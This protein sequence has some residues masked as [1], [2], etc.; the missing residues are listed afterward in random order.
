MERSV[1]DLPLDIPIV[2][3]Y[4]RLKKRKNFSFFYEKK[5][6]SLFLACQT[7]SELKTEVLKKY[8]I[9]KK[10]LIEKNFS[11]ILKQACFHLNLKSSKAKSFQKDT[12]NA[13]LNEIIF[14]IAAIEPLGI[15]VYPSKKMEDNEDIRN[16]IKYLFYDLPVSKQLLNLH[17]IKAIF[18][19]K[20]P[21]F[22]SQVRSEFQNI[23]N[24]LYKEI[25]TK[26]HDELIIEMLIGNILSFYCYMQPKHHELIVIPQKIDGHFEEIPFRVEKIKLTPFIFGSPIYA[27]GLKPLTQKGHPIFLCKGTTYPQDTGFVAAIMTDFTPFFSVGGLIYLFYKKKI[28]KWIKETYDQYQ[29]ELTIYGQSLGGASAYH[30]ALDNPNMVKIYGY[31]PPGLLRSTV[32]K[33]KDVLINGKIFCHENDFVHLLGKHPYGVEFY[34]IITEAK[35]N[36]FTAHS[37]AFGSEEVLVLRVNE[38]KDNNRAVRTVFE[39][40]HQLASVLIFVPTC[41]MRFFS[42]CI[43]Y[44]LKKFSKKLF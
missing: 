12:F 26:L 18:F 11:K 5:I 37:R 22:L 3:K 30:I 17:N 4:E 24:H 27:Y 20:N 33:Y 23:L 36:K 6:K 39:I 44:P 42:I 34:K 21:I 40:S 19:K 8:P 43:F 38:T 9:D 10:N 7:L 32:N 16:V 13:L 1:F 29:T 28:S 35:R 2:K 41:I 15:Q 31:V 14:T 25:T